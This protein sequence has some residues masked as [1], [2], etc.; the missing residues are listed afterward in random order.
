VNIF[1]IV[2]P[3]VIDRYVILSPP[4]DAALVAGSSGELGGAG[5]GGAGPLWRR[6]GA[7]GDPPEAS[8][9]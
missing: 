3:V 1:A 2:R 8:S 9:G 7:D 6:D 5:L 4:P